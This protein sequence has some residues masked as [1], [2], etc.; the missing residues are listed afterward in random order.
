VQAA[1]AKAN[2]EA[3]KGY[4]SHVSPD[5]K[6]SWSWFQMAGYGYSHAAE[7]LAQGFNDAAAV[8]DSFMHSA[9]HK[10]NI[11]NPDYTEI[12]IASAS[13]NYQGKTVTFVVQMFG[14]PSGAAPVATTIA[15]VQNLIGRTNVAQAQTKAVSASV[16]NQKIAPPVS[17]ATRTIVQPAMNA[18]PAETVAVDAP[19][20]NQDAVSAASSQALALATAALPAQAASAAQ[21]A[22]P[23]ASGNYLYLSIA[24]LM[25][26]AFMFL[27]SNT[28]SRK[29]V[30]A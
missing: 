23:S 30:R 27:L 13:G 15:A 17:P 20:S 21:P 19:A 8:N 2:D 9:T 12:G 10:A 16:A 25:T 14:S 24:V 26:M 7:N 3:A 18:M 6:T 4:F 29:A 5:G 1:Q 28:A 11:M 22:Y